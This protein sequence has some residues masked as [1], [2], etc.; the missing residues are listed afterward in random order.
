ME[1]VVRIFANPEMI[2]MDITLVRKTVP[3][4]ALTAG[5]VRT[6]KS[7]SQQDSALLDH[8]E[9]N[10]NIHLFAAICAPGCNAQNGY[11]DVPN[12]CK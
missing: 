8:N 1:V 6:A 9:A 7:V 5:L 10:F 2:I 4:S 3:K 11:C 12:E